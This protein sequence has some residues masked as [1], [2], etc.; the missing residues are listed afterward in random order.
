M[1]HVL[2]PR[3]G[4]RLMTAI[5]KVCHTKRRLSPW[6]RNELGKL[7]F[8]LEFACSVRKVRSRAPL[9]IPS[10]RKT[11]KFSQLIS[12][13]VLRV[14]SVTLD[15]DKRIRITGFRPRV[16]VL[17]CGRLDLGG[18]LVIPSRRRTEK[19]S[20]LV[21]DLV[22]R[23][24][25]FPSDAEAVSHV[26]LSLRRD[27]SNDSRNLFRQRVSRWTQRNELGKLD[28]ALEFSCSVRSWV[29]LVISSR[30]RNWKVFSTRLG[31][32]SPGASIPPLGFTHSGLG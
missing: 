7:D 30:R 27:P 29:P 3:E 22:L 4:S 31:C 21:S 28:F 9:V 1:S 2:L 13:V 5:L 15:I 20:Q 26:P 12:D 24:F 19:F 16:R 23:V 18:P 17:L 8:A 6:T 14:A 10:C 32:C 11:E 25:L